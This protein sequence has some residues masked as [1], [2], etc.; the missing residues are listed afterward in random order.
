MKDGEHERASMQFQ[1]AEADANLAVA[2]AR[3]SAAQNQIGTGGMALFAL[4]FF[5][6]VPHFLALAWMYKDDYRRGGFKMLSLVDA[7]GETCFRQIQV[8]SFLLLLVSLFPYWYGLA[9]GSYLFTALALGGATLLLARALQRTGTRQAAVRLF[10]F[11]IL[12]LPAVLIVMALDK[13]MLFL[14]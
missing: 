11:S 10:L 13:R 3:E 9:G 2:L 14:G 8:Q 7:S 4:L 1:R 6:Q 12:Y 5:W